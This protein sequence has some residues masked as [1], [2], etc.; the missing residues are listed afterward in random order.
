MSNSTSS[1]KAHYLLALVLGALTMLAA[2]AAARSHD[3]PTTVLALG[4]VVVT[5]IL[6]LG[7][8]LDT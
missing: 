4:L 2:T 6:T 7:V 5:S 8:F 3:G 1:E